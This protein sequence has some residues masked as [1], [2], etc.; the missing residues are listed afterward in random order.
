M[1]SIAIVPLRLVLVG[2]VFATYDLNVGFMVRGGPQT[3]DLLNDSIGMVLILIGVTWIA[4]LKSYDVFGNVMAALCGVA[5]AFLIGSLIKQL[6]PSWLAALGTWIVLLKLIGVASTVIFCLALRHACLRFGAP[7]AASWWLAAALAFMTIQLL[8]QTL[9]IVAATSHDVDLYTA[10]Q[11][12][13]GRSIPMF[14]PSCRLF[15]WCPCAPDAR[16]CTFNSAGRP[17]IREVTLS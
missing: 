1:H 4:T 11:V 3:I 2:G 7:A 16:T 12:F 13:L 17:L 14:W 8:G 9:F 6:H 10:F 5:L 15:E